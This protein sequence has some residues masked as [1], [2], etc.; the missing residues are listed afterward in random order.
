MFYSWIRGWR[1]ESRA[2]A[3][4]LFLHV[5]SDKAGCLVVSLHH[6]ACSTAAKCEPFC[7]EVPSGSKG[8]HAEF[9][10]PVE[11]KASWSVYHFCITDGFCKDMDFW[12]VL[13]VDDPTENYTAI[14]AF[15]SIKVCPVPGSKVVAQV[16]PWAR[17]AKPPQTKIDAAD[18]SNRHSYLV[19][20]YETIFHVPGASFEDFHTW[21]ALAD[22]DTEPGEPT[23]KADSRFHIILHNLSEENEKFRLNLKVKSLDERVTEFHLENRHTILRLPEGSSLEVESESQDGAKASLTLQVENLKPGSNVYVWSELDHESF[24][25]DEKAL[26]CKALL[27]FFLPPLALL[28]FCIFVEMAKGRRAKRPALVRLERRV[29]PPSRGQASA[30]ATLWHVLP[31]GDD[32]DKTDMLLCQPQVGGEPGK[33]AVAIVRGESC[34]VE[35]K[36]KLAL[37]LRKC[38]SHAWPNAYVFFLG[39]VGHS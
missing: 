12:H 34:A 7:I 9:G 5:G 37:T 15:H 13:P 19:Q 3:L 6:A 8:F 1:L 32:A 30:S 39:G 27:C 33:P 17:Q 2:H 22:L 20:W 14:K 28:L 24:N 16:C 21:N 36:S 18:F 35:T 26:M 4:G 11:T 31:W 25:E 29:G 10:P 23:K 38:L